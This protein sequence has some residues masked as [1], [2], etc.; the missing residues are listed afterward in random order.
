MAD[1]QRI[2]P[3]HDVESPPSPPPPSS[4]VSPTAPLLHNSSKSDQNN[5]VQQQYQP[6][7]PLQHSTPPVWVQ[8]PKPKRRHNICCR[9]FCWTF[10][11]LL[12]L[13]IIIAAIIGILYLVFQ[14]KLPKYTVDK[15]SVTKF[16]QQS[17][18]S[19]LYAEFNVTITA[20]NPNK[21]IGIYYQDGSHI[22]GW[23]NNTKLCEGSMPIFYQGHK[24]TTV[25]NLALKGQTEDSNGLINSVFQQQQ[26]TGN[27]P[28]N[29]KVKQPVRIKLGGLKL[30]EVKFKVKCKLTVDN[31]TANDQI[32]I[33]SSSCHFSFSL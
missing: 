29:L 12:T 23:Y 22:S 16:E 1:Q 13:I 26:L 33:Q 27:I 11:I 17:D 21:K 32:S 10:S 3:I 15:L 4:Q 19:T 14:P 5:N 7:Q 8:P 2:H 6:L 20:K 28:L 24:N 30:M 31:L 9:C 18:N 25:L